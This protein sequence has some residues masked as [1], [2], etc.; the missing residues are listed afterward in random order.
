MFEN[1]EEAAKLL[2]KKIDFDFDVVAG[3]LRGGFIIAYV[4]AKEKNKR[5]IPIIS[6][7]LRVPFEKEL[8]FGAICEDIIVLNEE[9]IKE[10]K[11]KKE[12]V[13]EEIEN[14]K[15]VIEEMK[16]IFGSEFTKIKNKK[17][18][19]VDDGIATGATV[20]AAAKYMKRNNEVIIATPI[21]AYD[22]YLEIS[23]EFKVIALEIPKFMPAI[24]MFYKDFRE[25]KNEEILELIK[26][27]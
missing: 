8:A 21:I 23:K 19:I 15:K 5:A 27:L 4:I 13:E 14:Q 11:L 26:K 2:I 7:K 12:E 1:R 16:K 10:L 20:K 3:I 25:V 6:R 9:I 22:T 18:L 17:V 24:G